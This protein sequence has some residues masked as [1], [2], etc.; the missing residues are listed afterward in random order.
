MS[1]E[2][3]QGEHGKMPGTI[4]LCGEE[5]RDR[6]RCR[7]GAW[8]AD[9]T[10]DSWTVWYRDRKVEAFPLRRSKTSGA[11]AA[12]P[13]EEWFS[14]GVVSDRHRWVSSV[15]NLGWGYG[16][17]RMNGLYRAERFRASPSHSGYRSGDSRRVLLYIRL[18][19]R[20]GKAFFCGGTGWDSGIV[21][22]FLWGK[23]RNRQRLKPHPGPC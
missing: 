1:F 10:Q 18:S 6:A 12:G 4:Y 20:E 7:K 11:A 19:L 13:V 3:R 14:R 2:P 16:K 22:V 17:R 8:A 23:R 21:F 5:Q 15:E 9:T